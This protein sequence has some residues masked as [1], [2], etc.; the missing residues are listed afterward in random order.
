M[1]YYYHYYFIFYY[2]YYN[3]IQILTM[4]IP[5]MLKD[6]IDMSIS[7]CF[8]GKKIEMLNYSLFIIGQMGC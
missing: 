2:H 4:Y 8:T 7:F 5:G 1:F 6:D 3:I